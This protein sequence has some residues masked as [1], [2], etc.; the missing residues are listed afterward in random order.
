MPEK[1]NLK[2]EGFF[3]AMVSVVSAH[4]WLAP[5]LWACGE[6][7]HHCGGNKWQRRHLT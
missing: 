2:E 6:A 1:I 4:G 3:L 5:W 7:K